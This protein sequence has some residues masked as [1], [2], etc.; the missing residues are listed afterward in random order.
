[1]SIYVDKKYIALASVKLDRFKQKSEFL[2]NFRCPYCG[3]SSKNKIKARGYVYRKKS[4][5]FFMCHNCGV[6]TTLGRML[7]HVDPG[8]YSRYNMEKY[9]AGTTNRAIEEPDFDLPEI[10][11]VKKIEFDLP[12]ISSLAP[13]HPARQYLDSRK[14]PKEAYNNIFFSSDYKALS[15]VVCQYKDKPVLRNDE[16]IAIPFR[17]VDGTLLGVQ[18]RALGDSKVRYILIKVSEDSKK[19]FGLDKVDFSKPVY[20]V[21]G[22]FDAMF[23][24]NSLAMMDAQ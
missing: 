8:M 4:D 14:L 3:D 22:P 23:L 2:W 21:E 15:D 24:E 20:V 17:D 11:H 1:M 9:Q 7:K 13:N 16:R 10:S 18:G 12:A 5:L 6:S 19:I